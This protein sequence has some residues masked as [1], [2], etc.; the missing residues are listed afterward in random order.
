M[1][2]KDLIDKT[3]SNV[4]DSGIKSDKVHFEVTCDNRGEITAMRFSLDAP[5]PRE[6][7]KAKPGGSAQQE[8]YD[9]N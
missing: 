5:M 1:K 6:E 2:L 3:M 9:M 4:K 8:F 7:R